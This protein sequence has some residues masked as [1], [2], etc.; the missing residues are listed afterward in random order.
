MAQ[1]ALRCVRVLLD[2]ERAPA[3]E[4]LK[5]LRP[6]VVP[7]DGRRI[8][9]IALADEPQRDGTV[10]VHVEIR[11]SLDA[12]ATAAFSADCV[13]RAGANIRKTLPPPAWQP[14]PI[15][16][17]KE[18][19]GTLFFQGPMFQH[20]TALHDV[21][22]THCIAE[23][24]IPAAAQPYAGDPGIVLGPASIRD[25]FLHAIQVCVPEYRILPV[26]LDSLET[27]GLEGAT[28]FIVATERSRTAEEFS[29]DIDVVSAAGRVL[30][31]LR[32]YHCRIIDTFD[33]REVL[34]R[35]ERVHTHALQRQV[36]RLAQTRH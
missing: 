6:I 34:E 24:D 9:I 27:Y 13:W 2:A 5:F 35:I 18:L 20:V 22:A 21:S 3:L 28:A 8:R 32:G 19:Y 25:C 33:D 4:N 30:E 31:Q 14:L 26:G 36:P 7:A 10:R 16:P 29:Y 17:S 11:S 1:V 23:V 12:Y 15:D